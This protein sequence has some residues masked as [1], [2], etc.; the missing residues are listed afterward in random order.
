MINKHINKI[1]MFCKE[2]YKIENYEAAVNDE[3]EMWEIH[4]RL[5][6]TINGEYAHSVE[7]LIRMDMYY[8]RPYFELIFLKQSEHK[9]LHLQLRNREEIN[10][11]ISNT[12]KGHIVTQSTR[13]KITK[14][15][16]ELHNNWI[17]KSEFNRKFFEH[18]GITD[19]ED[20]KLCNKERC[21]Y[22]YHKKCSWE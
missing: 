5:E 4:H 1:R 9:K 16:E 14:R 19:K 13:D 7:D 11:K 20:K 22:H 6:L 3:T 10:D 15:F 12:L 8:N 17:N 21:Y 2:Y 18:Y